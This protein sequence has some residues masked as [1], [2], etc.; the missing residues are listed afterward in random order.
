MK[1]LRFHLTMGVPRIPKLAPP[2]WLASPER[3]A[4]VGPPG[5][6]GVPASP[7]PD[8]ASAP[9]AARSSRAAPDGGA[10]WLEACPCAKM[11]PPMANPEIDTSSPRWPRDARAACAFTFDLD[12]ET[13]WMARGVHEPVTLSQ[14]R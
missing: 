3:S 5:A 11:T 9:S 12:A 4:T 1:A 10:R 7:A 14:G 8:M 2:L 6:G 13:L